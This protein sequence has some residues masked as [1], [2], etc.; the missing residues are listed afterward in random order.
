MKLIP[1]NGIPSA[2]S[3]AALA[4]AIRAG[5][6]IT[7]RE[8]RYQKPSRAGRASRS[9]RRRRKAGESALTRLP[10]RARIAGRTRSAIAAAISATSEPPIPIEYRNRC[11][12][13]SSEAS[14]PAT[15]IELNSTVRPAVFIVRRSASSPGPERA[16]SSR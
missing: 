8:S 12:K 6:R 16:I 9:A 2:I 5:N 1:K 13:T 3:N 14:A 7:S 15:V 4:A 11:G 10:S